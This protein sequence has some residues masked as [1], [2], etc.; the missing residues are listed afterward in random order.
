MLVFAEDIGGKKPQRGA[1]GM[2]GKKE[3][4]KPESES[5]EDAKHI[6]T[7][8]VET[9]LWSE[10]FNGYFY[11]DFIILQWRCTWTASI[12]LILKYTHHAH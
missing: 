5:Q 11:G 4:A 7:N 3:R 8:F 1:R 6:R 9:W 12:F 2:G 10:V